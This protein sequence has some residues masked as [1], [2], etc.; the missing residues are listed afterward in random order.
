MKLFDL[1][2]DTISEMYASGQRLSDNTLDISLRKAE[3]YEQYSQL[4]AIYSTQRLPDEDNWARFF[5]ILRHAMPELKRSA[6]FTPYL[7]VEG[8]KLLGGDLS[9]LDILYEKGVRFLTLVWGDTCCVGGAHNTDI[10]LTPFGRDVVRRC[11]ELGI[12]PDLSHSSDVTFAEACEIAEAAGKPVIATHSNSRAVCN[13]RR[14]LTDDMFRRIRDLG[15][16]VGISMCRPHLSE[17][18]VCTVDTVLAHIEHD[19]SLGGENTLC[20]GGDLDGI[21]DAAPDGIRT[22]ADMEKI[23]D[24]MAAHGYSDTLIG[25]IMYQNAADFMARNQIASL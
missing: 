25:K 13:H 7:A 19:L 22:V 8:G 17:T 3:K 9:R 24:A 14:N 4:F 20:M 12:V 5:C 18:G 16:I 1:H 10:G 11:L 15:G 6:R 2:C 23:A 21:G